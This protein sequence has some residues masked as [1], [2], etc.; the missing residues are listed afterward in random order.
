MRTVQARVFSEYPEVAGGRESMS[1]DEPSA[2]SNEEP[3]LRRVDLTMSD[4]L[5]LFLDAM[6][7]ME[8]PLRERWVAAINAEQYGFRM[9]EPDRDLDPRDESVPKE[10]LAIKLQMYLTD[11]GEFSSILV[12]IPRRRRRWR[13]RGGR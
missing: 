2:E 6:G 8:E 4:I 10:D 3:W 12:P 9:V 13:L 1:E 5:E 7:A 11:E